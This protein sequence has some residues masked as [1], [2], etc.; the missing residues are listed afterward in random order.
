METV[1]AAARDVLFVD[2]NLTEEIVYTAQGREPKTLRARVERPKRQADGANPIPRLINV[3]VLSVA[4]SSS[5]G[6]TEVNEGHDI[7]SL[8]LRLGDCDATDLRIARVLGHN[9]MEWKLEAEA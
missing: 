5:I 4:N 2:L 6:V 9:E 8:K 1:F 7:V 3:V